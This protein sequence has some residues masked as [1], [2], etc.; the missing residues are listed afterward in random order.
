MGR[1]YPL[2]YNHFRDRLH[3]AFA[4]QAHLTD[5]ARIQ[6]GIKRAEF[7]KKGGL[8]EGLHV[9]CRNHCKVAKLA[10]GRNRSTV[11]AF[12]YILLSQPTDSSYPQVLSKAIPIFTPALFLTDIKNP[13]SSWVS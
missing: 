5:D 6:E 12:L 2:G 3:S 4:G 1:H 8:P 10:C 9:S 13:M 7:V 11:H